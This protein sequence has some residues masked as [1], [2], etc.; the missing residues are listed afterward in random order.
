MTSAEFVRLA[1]NRFE[2]VFD[3]LVDEARRERA[4]LLLLTGYAAAW[5]L[6]ATIAKSGED[7]H[8][9]MGEMVAWSRE[10]GLGTPKHPPLA[11]WLVGARFRVFPRE[12]WAYYLFAMILPTVALWIAWRISARYLPPDKRVVGIALLTFLPFYNFLAFKFNA[13]AVLTPL[14]A[15][16]TWWFLRSF[17][18]RRVGWAIL[19]GVA[20]SA[21]MLGKY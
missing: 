11:A 15:A 10:V 6:Y 16:T 1:R 17:E 18:S 13:N 8:P 21:A 9:D 20:A 7:I 5:T 12:D 2:R 14:W 3:A 4:M 19:T